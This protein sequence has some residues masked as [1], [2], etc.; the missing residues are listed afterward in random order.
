MKDP[1]DEGEG[2][3]SLKLVSRQSGTCLVRHVDVSK[4]NPDKRPLKSVGHKFSQ[5]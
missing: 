1:C 4:V 5:P 3:S 2:N